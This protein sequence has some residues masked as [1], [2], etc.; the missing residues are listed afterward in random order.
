MAD[1]DFKNSINADTAYVDGHKVKLIAVPDGTLE[2]PISAN[3]EYGYVVDANSKKHRVLLTAFLEG[4]PDFKSSL[5]EDTAYMTVNGQKVKVRL[6]AKLNG[7]QYLSNSANVNDGYTEDDDGNKHRTMLVTMPTGTLELPTSET[8]DSAYVIDDNGKKHKVRLFAVLAGGTTIVEVTVSGVPPLSLVGAVADSLAS[9]K[10]FGGTAL[11]TIPSEYTQVEY[12]ERPSGNT[13]QYIE[14][15]W[16]PNLAKDIRIQGTATYMGT[17]TDY[18]PILLGN[19]TGIRSSTLNIE[20]D[21]RTQNNLRIYTLKTNASSGNDLQVG[22]FATNAVVDFDIQITGSTGALAVSATAGGTTETGSGTIENVGEQTLYN[23]MLFKDHR[24]TMTSASKVASRIHYLKATEDDK[25]VFELI[26]VKRKSDSV[27]GFYDKVSG[28]FLTN[29]GTGSFTAGNE[30]LP[31]PSD[32]MDI[33]C[34]NGALKIL[35]KSDWTI[36]TNPTSVAGQGVF[37]SSDG[38]WYNANDRGAGCAIP[39]TIGKQY[40]LVIHKKTAGLGTILRYGQSPQET[41]TGAGIQ[42]TDWYRGDI[43]DGQMISFVAKLP[44]LVMQLSAVAV[45]A[46]MIQEA[47]EVIEA[48]GGDYTFLKYIEATGT[49]YIDTGIPTQEGIGFDV[50]FLTNS[51]IGNS[52]NYGCILGGR[53]ASGNNDVQITTFGNPAGSIRYGSQTGNN[54]GIVNNQKLHVSLI[55]SVATLDDGTTYTVLSY[56][57]TE[58]NNIYLFGL[59]NDGTL[60]Q[61]GSGCRIYNAKLYV[62]SNVV[63]DFIPVKRNSD[64][65]LGMYDTISKRFFTN[66]GTGTFVAGTPLGDGEVLKLTP[67]NDTAGVANLF[68]VN[69]YKDVQEIITGTVKHKVNVYVLNGEETAWNDVVSSSSYAM[70]KTALGSDSNVLPNKSTDVICSHYGVL[71]TESGVGVQDIIWVGGSNVNFKTKATYATLQDWKDYLAAQYAAGTPVIVI[72]PFATEY[73]EPAPI[74]QS[75][76]VVD[77][78]NTVSLT[79]QGMT[80]LELEATYTAGVSVTIT[81][82]ENANIGNDVDVVIA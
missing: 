36:F 78:D 10:A 42:L 75:M 48:Q 38:K 59:N 72:V 28:Q 35:D 13:E 26:P 71:A 41:P 44:Y 6:A 77:G 47:V 46:G 68:A 70:P 73:T 37:I 12:V 25:V 19:Y 49:Q 5:T 61:T 18:R 7:T 62:N 11:N 51:I 4:D 31:T 27:V 22:P 24:A 33:Y 66:A 57:F 40:T 50:T 9:L 8:D 52:G 3:D 64:N 54:A 14:T 15:N 1:I 55:N 21:G 29:Q 60:V 39:L 17:I 69:T 53:K 76:T 45:E 23:M 16:K 67:S 74:A 30:V 2:L 80:P 56:K 58:S 82:I 81:E 65:V 34:N 79:Q 20:F 63:A 43:T 32:P